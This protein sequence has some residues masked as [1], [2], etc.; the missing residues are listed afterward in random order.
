MSS[1][2]LMVKRQLGE[3]QNHGQV[4]VSHHHAVHAIQYKSSIQVMGVLT[5]IGVAML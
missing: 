3:N 5:H 4:I 1:F 2:E